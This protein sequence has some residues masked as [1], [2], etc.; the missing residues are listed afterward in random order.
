[1]RVI[2]FDTSNYTTSCAVF[3]GAQGVNLGRLLDV[4]PGELGLRQSE[5]LFSH[6]KRLPEIAGGHGALADLVA[7]GASETPR[8]TEG[9]YMPCFLAGVMAARVLA[10]VEGLP[11]F[12]FSHQQG[13]IAAAAWSAGHMELLE[14]EHLAWHLSGGTTELLYVRPEGVAVRCAIVG[15]TRDV[16]AGQLIDRAGQALGL[17][18]PAGREMDALSQGAEKRE[19]Y[20]VKTDGMEFS[21]SGVEHKM[22]QKIEAGENP[23]EVAY[24]TLRSMIHAVHRAT[25]AAR[26][27]YGDLPVL[28]S[29]GVASN[30][31]LRAETPW[32]IFAEPRYSTDNAMGTAIL[33]W[34]AVQAHG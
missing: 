12:G 23:A 32:G 11:Y 20:K 14:R 33:T 4:K 19:Y 29:G 34:R 1:M 8:E 27:E 10:S 2:A 31:L 30:S 25:E 6:V 3:D 17:R 22:H 28:F 13:H 26:R 7:V 16:S 18:F 5:A 21:L 15:R 9:S 24:F